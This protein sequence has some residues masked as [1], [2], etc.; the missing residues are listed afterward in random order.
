LAAVNPP[1]LIPASSLVFG[2]EGTAVLVVGPDQRV[3]RKKIQIEGD[4]G[5]DLG[6]SEGIDAAD[7]VISNPSER[8][9]EGLEV[10]VVIPA[11]PA[12]PAPAAA[13]PSATP[14]LV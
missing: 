14:P 4:Y 11:P 9:A 7:R 2:A 1:L 8:L 3:R 5:A 12:T 13:P 6:I 10:E